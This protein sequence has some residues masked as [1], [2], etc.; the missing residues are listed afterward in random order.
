M[1]EVGLLKWLKIQSGFFSQ[2]PCHFANGSEQPF[3]NQKS[4]WAL[5]LLYSA[6]AL[7]W[8][9][10]VSSFAYLHAVKFS[11]ETC[12]TDFSK[13]ED[14]RLRCWVQIVRAE[15][16]LESGKYFGTPLRSITQDKRLTVFWFLT[17]IWYL[18]LQCNT[19]LLRQG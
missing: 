9:R 4:T 8:A 15:L 6:S 5:L 16:C 12:L 13:D 19:H 3:E 7:P 1:K 2:K 17:G 18:L 14:T 10:G 11:S